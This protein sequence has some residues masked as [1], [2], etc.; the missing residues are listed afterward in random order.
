MRR[1]NTILVTYMVVFLGCARASH[2]QAAPTLKSGA[3]GYTEKLQ[4]PRRS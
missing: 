4:L 1:L 2:A 3:G